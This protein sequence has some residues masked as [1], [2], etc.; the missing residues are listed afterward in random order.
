M[1]DVT[2][3]DERLRVAPN[4]V[5]VQVVNDAVDTLATPGGDDG[6]HSGI[7]EG[8]VQVGGAVFV[9]SGH[10]PPLIEDVLTQLDP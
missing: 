2:E 6:A 7:T 5:D 10:V 3:P 8:G 1:G 9:R 4:G